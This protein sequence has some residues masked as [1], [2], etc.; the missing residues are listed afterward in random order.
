MHC[1]ATLAQRVPSV[2]ASVLQTAQRPLLTPSL[3]FSH[4]RQECNTLADHESSDS[5][6]KTSPNCRA[7]H[8]VRAL[9]SPETWA[10]ASARG[11]L[12][13]RPHSVP[14]TRH[15]PNQPAPAHPSP[16]STSAF[17]GVLD[18]HYSHMM[19]TYF[20]NVCVAR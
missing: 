16:W 14:A 13:P 9:I 2:G 10:T 12:L 4:C 19:S 6:S 17:A 5:L 8:R 3:F 11:S 18:T 7:Q 1:T 20:I 15:H